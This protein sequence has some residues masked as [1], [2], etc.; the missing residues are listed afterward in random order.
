MD[1][2]AGDFAEDNRA[3]YDLLAADWLAFGEGGLPHARVV[4]PALRRLVGDPTDLDV[5]ELGCG[6]GGELA[7]LVDCGAASVTGIDIAQGMLDIAAQRAPSAR[8][9]RADI[10]EY[11]FPHAAYDLVCASMALHYSQRF[12]EVL[13]L[14]RATL[15][16][17]GRLV[18]TLPHPVYYG[19]ERVNSQQEKVI[20]LGYR[21]SGGDW[22][23]WGD[24]LGVRQVATAIHR[25]F[26]VT[27]WLRPPELV[28]AA[29]TGAGL[30]VEALRAPRP[31]A[32]DDDPPDV[33]AWVEAHRRIPLLMAFAAVRD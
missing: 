15:R 27:F 32:A 29:L 20:R 3:T 2:H 24:Y 22:E 12:D 16:H 28:F 7:H 31:E 19:A 23:H 9:V 25:R 11:D 10:D 8:L 17:G 21:T 18:F 30:R 14:L 13:R 4:V 33:A 5:L 6:T 1:V 26:P